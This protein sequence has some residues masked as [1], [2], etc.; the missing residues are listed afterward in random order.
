MDRETL[1]QAIGRR[2]TA[3]EIEGVGS[4]YMREMSV[5]ERDE[6]R[7]RLFGADGTATVSA[8]RWAVET[9]ALTLC[10]EHGRRLFAD[11]DLSGL[12][13]ASQPLVERM[14]VEANRVN[15]LDA[16]ALEAAEKNSPPTEGDASS[17]A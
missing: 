15:R 12:L 9:L 10:D 3:V 4:V 16:G 6:L 13:D 5:G 7:R 14:F 11:G 8:T 2:V 1:L 17:S